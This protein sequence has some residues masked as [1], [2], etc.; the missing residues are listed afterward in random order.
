MINTLCLSALGGVALAVGQPETAARVLGLARRRL[1]K[2]GAHFEPLDRV[3]HEG[4]VDLTQQ[5]LGDHNFERLATEGMQ[6]SLLD[7]LDTARSLGC[8]L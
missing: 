1:E 7:A 2:M 8:E 4:Y 6:W 5:Q 3:A